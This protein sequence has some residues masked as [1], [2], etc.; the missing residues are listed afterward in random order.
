[1][2]TGLQSPLNR[3]LA[4]AL[5]VDAREEIKTA[6]RVG[7]CVSAGLKRAEIGERLGLTPAEVRAAIDRLKRASVRLES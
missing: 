5:Q 3:R 2:D 1:M 6:M 7:V 4:R